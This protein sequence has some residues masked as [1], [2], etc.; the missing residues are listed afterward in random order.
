MPLSS[1]IFSLR[2]GDVLLALGGFFFGFAS[3]AVVLV[4]AASGVARNT[5]EERKAE[6]EG[7]V[8]VVSMKQLQTLVH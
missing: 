4:G 7:I 8:I 2:F 3:R 1:G 5:G 6:G